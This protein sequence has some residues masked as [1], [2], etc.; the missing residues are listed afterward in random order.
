MILAVVRTHFARLKR[1]RAALVLSFVVPVVFFSVFASIFGGARN[2]TPRIRLIAVDEDGSENSRRFPAALK[3][4]KALNVLLSSAG[5]NAGG[6]DVAFDRASAEQ[7]VRA[8]T[9]PVALIIPKGFGA[10]PIGFGPAE[11]RPKLLLLADSSDLIAPQVVTGLLQKVSMT[12]MPDAMAHSGSTGRM[13]RADRRTAAVENGAPNCS[14]APPRRP[15][16]PWKSATSSAKPRRTRPRRFWPRASASCS[17]SSPR[18]ARRRA[19]RGG[20]ERHARSHPLDAGH[21]D[22]APARQARLPLDR[23]GPAADRDV[24]LGGDVLRPRAPPPHP[25]LSHHERRDRAR[26]VLLRAPP[27]RRFQEPHAARG[28]LEP[29]DPGHVGP[30]RK[31]GPA[32]PP[33]RE[34]PEARAHHVERLGDRRLRQGLLAGGAARQPLAPGRRPARG[35]GRLFAAARRVA[36]RWDVA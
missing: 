23:R 10:A 1:D 35:R 17:S 3:A 16:S 24:R 14:G 20:G 8:G 32:L 18:R 22:A 25:G 36:R 11:G 7:A 12:A 33:L 9:A 31:H 13:G 5:P 34:G 15:S 26:R 28:D 21:D 4:E 2:A 19:H 6:A 29:L 27:R 30:R